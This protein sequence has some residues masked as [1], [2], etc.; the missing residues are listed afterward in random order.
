MAAGWGHEVVLLYVIAVLAVVAPAVLVPLLARGP[1]R[2]VAR[3]R[4]VDRAHAAISGL[5]ATIGRVP[6]AI[7][8]LLAW[9]AAVIAVFWPL[10]ELLASLE[11]AIDWPT[12]L[13]VTSRRSDGFENFNWAY[14]LLGD[15][16]PLKIVSLVGAVVFAV[17]WRRR[18]WI[19]AL[20]ILGQFPLEQYVQEILKLTVDRGHPPTGLGSYPSGGIA[21]IVL[22]FGTIALFV[23]LTWKVGARFKV[24]LG[25]VVAVAATYEGYSRIYVEKH[26]LTDVIG[27]LLFGPALLLGYIVAVL[28]LADRFPVGAPAVT[29]DP[30][31]TPAEP[32]R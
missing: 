31:R 6:T 27:G 11:D 5:I 4:V 1:A 18:W 7:A 9:S 19:P 16:D 23:A 3:S 2:R 15:R 28:I 20:A 13:W 24:V 25:T 8:V 32:V 14:T 21:R 26:W 29:D 12:L 22:T 10:G 30:D 17:L